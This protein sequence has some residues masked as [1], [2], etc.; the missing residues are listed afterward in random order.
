VY[1][2]VGLLMVTVGNDRVA[3]ISDGALNRTTLDETAGPIANIET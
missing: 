1:A 3:R 2:G